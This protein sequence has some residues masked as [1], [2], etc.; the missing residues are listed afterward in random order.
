L[1]RQAQQLGKDD[2]DQDGDVPIAVEKIFHNQWLVA[3]G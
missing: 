3:G 1:N 2:C